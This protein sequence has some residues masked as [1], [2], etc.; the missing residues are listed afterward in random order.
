MG[1]L[2]VGAS[3]PGKWKDTLC[4]FPAGMEMH[5]LDV[6]VERTDPVRYADVPK[7]ALLMI[8]PIDCDW[9]GASRPFLFEDDNEVYWY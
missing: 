8:K 3:Q 1:T 9:A 5:S 4:I 2:L 6:Q 7:N